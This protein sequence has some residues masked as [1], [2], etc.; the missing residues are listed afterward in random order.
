[1]RKKSH[2]YNMPIAA[3]LMALNSILLIAIGLMLLF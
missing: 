2:K 1:M 3:V